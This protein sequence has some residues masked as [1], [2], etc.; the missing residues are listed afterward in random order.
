[1]RACAVALAAL[2]VDACVATRTNASHCSA[3]RRVVVLKDGRSGSTLFAQLLA[4]TRGNGTSIDFQEEL[5]TKKTAETMSLARKVRLMAGALATTS[6][7]RCPDVLGFSLCP[8]LHDGTAQR[9]VAAALRA[10]L[11]NFPGTR[12]VVFSRS[13]L[14]RTALASHGVKK[15]KKKP[16]C[17]AGD[18]LA[19]TFPAANF[20]CEL[21]HVVAFR[22]NLYRTARRVG[23]PFRGV[24]FEE[25]LADAPA[26]MRGVGAWLG[27]PGRVADALAA[28]AAEELPSGRGG[29][30]V[31]HLDC[32]EETADRSGLVLADARAI[33]A[34]LDAFRRRAAAQGAAGSA[35]LASMARAA[36]DEAFPLVVNYTATPADVAT[37]C[38]K[39]DP[40]YACVSERPP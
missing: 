5:I 7:D 32:A 2:L 40:T 38:A 8:S 23:A 4:K 31:A 3:T 17:A 25:L 19:T 22:A 37:P 34:A 6:K 26:T 10:L 9:D 27:V 33:L 16:D 13:N 15:H 36:N 24:L 12:L 39:V 29:P 30:P 35:C 18:V 14:F 20:A 1:M 11:G 21:P 28:H